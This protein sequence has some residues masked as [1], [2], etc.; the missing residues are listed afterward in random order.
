MAKLEEFLS[1]YKL[2]ETARDF[3]SLVRTSS[4]STT[5]TIAKSLTIL[6]LHAGR[7][8]TASLPTFPESL[9][10]CT[11]PEPKSDVVHHP[12]VLGPN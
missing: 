1:G 5:S 9:F 6:H 11:L 4:T 8:V 3:V 10:S 2:A 7:I 12:L